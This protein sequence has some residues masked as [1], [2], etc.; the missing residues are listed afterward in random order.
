MMKGSHGQ[1]NQLHDIDW[2]AL[3]HAS[4]ASQLTT[5]CVCVSTLHLCVFVVIIYMIQCV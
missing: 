4:R 5:I 1:T 2:G 3:N